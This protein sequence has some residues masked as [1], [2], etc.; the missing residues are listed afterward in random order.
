MTAFGLSAISPYALDG[1][2]AIFSGPRGSGIVAYAVAS[3]VAITAGDPIG[4]A[5]QR[6]ELLDAFL[7]HCRRQ[8][9]MPAFYQI[10][11]QEMGHYRPPRSA[12]CSRSVRMP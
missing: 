3:G 12:A 9:W 6:E 10:L 8:G 4:P 2:K 1:D 11:P 7:A 5:D